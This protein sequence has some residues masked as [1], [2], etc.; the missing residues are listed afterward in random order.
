MAGTLSAAHGEDAGAGG[1]SAKMSGDPVIE[2]R[3]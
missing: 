3:I 1:F 2:K